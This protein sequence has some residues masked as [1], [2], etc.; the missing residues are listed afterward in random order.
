MMGEIYG[1]D[2]GLP[3]AERAKKLRESRVALWDVAKLCL[4]N[5]SSDASMREVEVNDFLDLLQR[6]PK[7]ERILFNGT[8][9]QELFQK[10]VLPNLR[11]PHGILPMVRLPSTS[12]AFAAMTRT[13][14]T[15]LW[16]KAL[17]LDSSWNPPK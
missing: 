4:R 16:R 14:K 9:A 13:Q 12:P 3:Y 15:A 6:S 17:N 7:L 2:P 5:K 8:K 11:W 1:F 10:L